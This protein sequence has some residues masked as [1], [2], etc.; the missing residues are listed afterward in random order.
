MPKLD[1]ASIPS[2]SGSSYPPQFARLMSGRHTQRLA[3]AGGLTQFGVN[4][5]TLAPG[6]LSSMRHWHRDEDEFVIVTDGVC[7]LVEDAGETELQRGDCAAFPANIPNGHHIVN[8]TDAPASF[9]VV[10]TN[11]PTELAT[12]SDIDMIVQ[13]DGDTAEFRHKDGRPYDMTDTDS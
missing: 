7:T 6:G 8:R 9:L 12:Y 2:T 10:G 5:V 1:L 4:L 11:S 13:C 3:E